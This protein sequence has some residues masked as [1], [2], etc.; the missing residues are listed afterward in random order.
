LVVIRGTAKPD[1]DVVANTE[2]SAST[3]DSKVDKD[4]ALP[5][6]IHKAV[7]SDFSICPPQVRSATP[8]MGSKLVPI[9]HVD[10]E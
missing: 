7:V 5:K 4:R 2:N 10:E 9:L 3:K 1:K 8:S 6:E